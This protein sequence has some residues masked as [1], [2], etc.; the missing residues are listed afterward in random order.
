MDHIDKSSH[1]ARGQR[2]KQAQT[3]GNRPR[4]VLRR[5]AYYRKPRG[6]HRPA[7]RIR[8]EAEAAPG[9]CF[10]VMQVPAR[11]AALTGPQKPRSHIASLPMQGPSPTTQAGRRSRQ[12]R[13][14]SRPVVFG[15]YQS[16]TKRKGGMS[17]TL[18][19]GLEQ[20]HPATVALPG[21]HATPGHH[22]LPCRHA[23]IDARRWVRKKLLCHPG[24]TNVI[25]ELK[26]RSKRRACTSLGNLVTAAG[27][28]PRTRS[29][30]VERLSTP[31]R[32]PGLFGNL[33]HRGVAEVGFCR[34][35]RSASTL[36]SCSSSSLNPAR[37][38]SLAEL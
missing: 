13:A 20:H 5:Y 32:C 4:I 22:P 1:D 21:V 6:C 37:A 17:N 11:Q 8:L 3:P 24:R 28:C 27:T 30:A 14:A 9:I 15:S 36:V 12:P 31:R 19:P 23:E 29:W 35:L 18:N 7:N 38:T 2:H 33:T 26:T 25:T 34:A 16:E 10:P